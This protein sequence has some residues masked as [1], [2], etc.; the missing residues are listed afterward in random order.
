MPLS[1]RRHRELLKQAE[2]CMNTGRYTECSALLEAVPPDERDYQLN[3][4][5]AESYIERVMRKYEGKEELLNSSLT[6]EDEQLMKTAVD[7]LR[8]IQAEGEGDPEWTLDMAM[9][10]CG[11]GADEK[12]TMSYLRKAFGD[13]FGA[14]GPDDERLGDA[15]AH[16][17][18]M[19][20]HPYSKEDEAAISAHIGK[21]FGNY[22]NMLFAMT[23]GDSFEVDICIVPPSKE[24]PYYTLVTMGSGTEPMNVPEDFSDIRRVEFVVKLPADWKL[25]ERALDDQRWN[26]PLKLINMAVD[27]AHEKGNYIYPGELIYNENDTPFARGTGLCGTIYLFTDELD[28]CGSGDCELQN[29]EDVNFLQIIPLYKEEMDFIEKN[30]LDDF[31]DKCPKEMLDAIEPKRRNIVTGEVW[32]PQKPVKKSRR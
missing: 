22:E 2:K 4:R 7:T 31:L 23:D 21:W 12:E 29:G 17:E 19:D 10:L 25:N 15:L 27:R 1:E 13:R 11:S 8:K 28:Q 20:G 32:K 14:D 30:D 26:W 18:K 16:V 24:K 3:L 6:A 5:L 9:A